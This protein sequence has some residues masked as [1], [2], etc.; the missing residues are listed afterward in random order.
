MNVYRVDLGRWGEGERGSQW[1]LR[2][3]RKGSRS[4]IKLLYIS[5][6]A[7]SGV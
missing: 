3:L 1:R 4:R 7:V 2:I 6:M 5:R